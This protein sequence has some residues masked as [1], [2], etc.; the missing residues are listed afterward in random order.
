MK[1]AFILSGGGAR[2]A[3]QVGVWEYLQEKGWDPDLIC[4]TS[5]GAINAVAIGSGM[6]LEKLM[7]IWKTLNRRTA[8]RWQFFRFCRHALFSK[9]FQ[10]L[11]DTARLRT[12]ITNALNIALELR[13]S[14]GIQ[15][16]LLGGR[17]RRESSSVVGHL[18]QIALKSLTADL[19]FLGVDGV[20]P[21]IGFTTPNMAE[22]NVNHRMIE[23][24]RKVV[25]VTDPSK[26]GRNSLAV[27]CGPDEVDMIITNSTV[28]LEHLQEFASL[29]IE[30]KLV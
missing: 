1:R 8:Y 2:G 30:I 19:F 17:L 23:V 29:G 3:F 13:E 4:G 25:V 14:A 26:F 18:T 20:D 9:S 16:I 11:M 5:V 21:R 22:A 27:I 7:H 24:A 15:V 12:T 6:P 28:P 10:P